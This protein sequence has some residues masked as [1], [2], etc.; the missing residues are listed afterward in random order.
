MLRYLSAILLCSCTLI[1]LLSFNTV[2]QDGGPDAWTIEKGRKLFM[3]KCTSCHKLST[4]D[5]MGPGLE[6]ITTRQSKTQIIAWA[7]N[8]KARIDMGDAYA[9][10]LYKQYKYFVPAKSGLNATTASYVYDFLYSLDND[11]L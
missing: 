5:H 2:P 4:E 10:E 8:H 11:G 6:H 3:N 7:V 9:Q 1:A